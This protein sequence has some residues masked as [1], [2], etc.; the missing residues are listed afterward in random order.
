MTNAVKIT[1]FSFHNFYGPKG[2]LVPL[3]NAGKQD[4]YDM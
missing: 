3:H 4:D 2:L 1:P